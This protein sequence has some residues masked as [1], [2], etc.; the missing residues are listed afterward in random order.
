MKNDYT[1]TNLLWSKQGFQ[2][3]YHIYIHCFTLEVFDQRCYSNRFHLV[4]KNVNQ[5]SRQVLAK[6]CKIKYSYDCLFPPYLMHT[7]TSTFTSQACRNMKQIDLKA[8]LSK[9]VNKRWMCLVPSIS[10]CLMS[11]KIP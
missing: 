10:Q 3:I 6:F 1:Y 4:M 8:E 5:N 2:V 11:D 9:M 7:S